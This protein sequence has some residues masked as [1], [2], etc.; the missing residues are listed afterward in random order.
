[1]SLASIKVVVY[2]FS[3]FCVQTA[4]LIPIGDIFLYS[5]TAALAWNL[6]TDPEFF[7]MFK[8]HGKGGKDA[9]RRGDVQR[10]IYFIKDGKFLA[11][12]PYKRS[13][14]LLWL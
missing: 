12:V 3:V 4:A 8:S 14:V 9:Q 2:I 5:N 6:P 1:M 11:K 13:A 10:N 7:A